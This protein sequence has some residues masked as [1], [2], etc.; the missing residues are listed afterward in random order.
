MPS[1]SPA[2]SSDSTQ[3]LYQVCQ[4]YRDQCGNAYP[5]PQARRY[6]ALA[7]KSLAIQPKSPIWHRTCNRELGRGW[8]V[9]APISNSVDFAVGCASR[10]RMPVVFGDAVL[11]SR[12]APLTGV[13]EWSL[14]R[15]P[16]NGG[17][18]S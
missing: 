15:S 12:N 9:S 11:K 2:Q 3:F 8:L 6:N 16:K 1:F 4:N 7:L 5:N 14:K 10:Q 17:S 18:S 13:L